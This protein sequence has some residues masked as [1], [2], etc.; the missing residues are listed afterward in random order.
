MKI[1]VITPCRNAAHRLPRTVRSVLEQ[2]GLS[3]GRVELEYIIIDG[4]SSDGTQELVKTWRDVTFLSEPDQGMF[5]ALTK[6]LQRCTGDIVT[7]INAGDELHRE[8][9]SLV[10]RLMSNEEIR[11]LT[12]SNCKI[13][14]AGEVID[15]WKPPRFR[16][17][18]VLN[19]TYLRGYPHPNIQQEGTFFRRELLEGMNWEKFRT[20]RLAG[21]YFLWTH[22]A[23]QTELHAVRSILG[24]FQVHAGQLS[25]DAAGYQIET[26]T[27]IRGETPRERVTRYWEF[28]CPAILK[29]LL[30]P[31]TLGQSKARVFKFDEGTGRWITR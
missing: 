18:Y 27:M 28:D 9:F 19:G 5:D 15:F 7:Y 14:E 6:G 13:N 24:S 29:G 11:W 17:E 23:A 16:R 22:F 8:A 20:Y 4:D 21:E 2:S 10:H 25:E 12:G 30:W 3:D 1:S 26:D 31:H